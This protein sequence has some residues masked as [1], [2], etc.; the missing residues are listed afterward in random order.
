MPVE[1][2]E[3]IFD[4]RCLED[5]KAGR[6][7]GQDRQTRLTELQIRNSL[8]LPHLKSSYPVEMQ[9]IS[10]QTCKESD[11]KSTLPFISSESQSLTDSSDPS[12]TK[13]LLPTEKS[14]K[15]EQ[16]RVEF[17]NSACFLYLE[18]ISFFLILFYF[19]PCRHRDN[20][21]SLL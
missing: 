1:D 9:F 14:K 21:L 10:P 11:L 7:T 3:E 8:C 12:M 19:F 6:P 13:S 2:E 5:L 17:V 20:D 4:N 16:V 18:Q 15:K